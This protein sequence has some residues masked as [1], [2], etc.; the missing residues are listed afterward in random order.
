M[1]MIK[2][3]SKKE[4]KN[5]KEKIISIKTKLTISLIFS[6]IIPLLIMSLIIIHETKNNIINNME[7]STSRIIEEVNKGLDFYFEGATT[8]LNSLSINEHFKDYNK[9]NKEIK[10]LFKDFLEQNKYCK[11]IYFISQKEDIYI[12]PLIDYNSIEYKTSSWYQNAINNPD[13]IKISEPYNDQI[14]QEKIIT[15]SKTINDNGSILGVIGMDISISDLFTNLNDLKLNDNLSIYAITP[16]GNI[17]YKDMKD[18]FTISNENLN[19]LNN[20]KD[21]MY[22]NIENGEKYYSFFEKN[23]ISD[24]IVISKIS[25]ENITSGLSSIKIKIIISFLLSL[26]LGITTSILIGKDI[27]L[28]I[29]NFKLTFDKIAKGDFTTKINIKTKDDFYLL[30]NNLNQMINNIDNIATNLKST[31]KKLQDNSINLFQLSNDSKESISQVSIAINEIAEGNLNLSNNVQESLIEVTKLSENL[32]EITSSNNEIDEISKV[33]KELSSQGINSVNDLIIKSEHTK[34]KSNVVSQCI[35][36]MKQSLE[37]IENMSDMIKEIAEQTNLLA[38]NAA[39]EAAKA[40]EHGKGFNVLAQ[41]IRKLADQANVSTEKIKEDISLI[42][43]KSNIT[44]QAMEESNELRKEQEDAINNTK[45]V[46]DN[47]TN[48]VFDLAEK[49]DNIHESLKIMNKNKECVINSIENNS[50]IAEETSSLTEEISASSI[51]VSKVV[52]EC[53]K[54]SKQ[55]EDLAND[56]QEQV[57]KFNC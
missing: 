29:N 28:N 43:K 7:L 47:I 30:G 44:I 51:E 54:S 39:I 40:G 38:L 15:L 4:E 26:I 5:N 37:N 35:L 24:W 16:K 18:N 45:K 12:D 19:T 9:N 2:I 21:G 17:L 22:I 14:T 50:A 52:E 25:E 8:T 56:L 41:E 11:N 48:S 1:E 32:E 31:S 13:E 57:N 27:N 3:K 42:N 55:L 33:T 46:F 53:E 10:K 20:T 36:D 6:T 34:N 23:N 49:I